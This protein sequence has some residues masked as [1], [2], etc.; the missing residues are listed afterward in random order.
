MPI[1]IYSG[2]SGLN[3]VDDPV[4]LP[5]QEG[6]LTD[7]QVAINISIDQSNRINRRIGTSR[8]LT[9]AY[10]SLF[11]DGGDCFVIRG[12]ALFQVNSNN[13][14]TGLRSEL[15]AGVKMDFDQ[16]GERTYY[17]NGYEIGYIYNSVSYTWIIG[18]YTGVKTNRQFDAPPVG[19]H[20]ADFMGRMFI[21]E[22][23]VLWWSEPFNFDIYDKA[24]SFVQFYDDIIMIQ[25]VVGGIFVSTDKKIYFLGGTNPK[26]FTFQEVAQFPAIEWTNTVEKVDA[27]DIGLDGGL[28]AMWASKEG[29][30]LGLPSG[31]IFNLNKNKVVYPDDA[32]TGFGC[33]RGYNFIHGVA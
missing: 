32:T 23:K 25:P 10:H 9:G 13:S 15:T 16:V 19:T 22:G 27:T 6:G 4:R 7:L 26:D 12:S 30:I 1:K 2:S 24:E 11:C 17:C 31:Q 20:L 18:D 28:S 33:L 3:T 29:A 21:A 5:F 8:L 14:L